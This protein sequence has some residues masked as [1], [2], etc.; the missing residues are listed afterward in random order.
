MPANHPTHFLVEFYCLRTTVVTAA[1]EANG[2]QVPEG[3]KDDGPDQGADNGDPEEVD[4]P[5]AG[6]DDDL[7]H[8]PDADQCGNDSSDEAKGNA[9]PDDSLSNQAHDSGYD[10]VKDKV[11]TD[12]PG[13]ATDFDGDT[14]GEDGD[15]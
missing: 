4:I 7:G 3:D 12:R 1:E 6:N 8:E 2:E 14:I 15:E 9:P 10:Q 5:D 11:E 13:V